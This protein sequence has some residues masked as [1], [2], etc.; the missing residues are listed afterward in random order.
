MTPAE[1]CPHQ[2]SN[3][4]CHFCSWWEQCRSHHIQPDRGGDVF[5][6]TRHVTVCS[7]HRQGCWLHSAPKNFP[8]ILHLCSPTI[9]F[10]VSG[11]T[12]SCVFTWGPVWSR[13]CETESVKVSRI[14]GP[15][16]RS[17]PVLNLVHNTDLPTGRWKCWLQPYSITTRQ[18]V[19]PWI[20][21]CL[22]VIHWS[23]SWGSC[24]R[25]CCI[26]TTSCYW[27]SQPQSVFSSSC[28]WQW[29]KHPPSTQCTQTDSENASPSCA[30]SRSRC[31][32][33]PQ[34]LIGGSHRSLSLCVTRM[35]QHMSGPV[36]P[37]ISQIEREST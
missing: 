27:K 29:R 8:H 37:H 15:G 36:L 31:R 33:Q 24:R 1:L 9:I 20:S 19:N 16:N 10:Q 4:L 30:P 25:Q 22:S 23:S 11:K 7:N 35:R 28:V 18:N 6:L 34:S 14:A 21:Y 32:R 5:L 3:P 2:W 13:R 17:E 26:T 12:H